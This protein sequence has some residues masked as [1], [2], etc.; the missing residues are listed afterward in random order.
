MVD[1]AQQQTAIRLQSTSRFL[2]YKNDIVVRFRSSGW[3]VG[4]S[5]VSINGLKE[6]TVYKA[7]EVVLAPLLAGKSKMA[8][9]IL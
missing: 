2:E 5:T 3:N 8:A 4:A 7:T 9:F 1:W 6:K